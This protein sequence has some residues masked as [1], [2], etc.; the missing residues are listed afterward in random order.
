M[1]NEG[2]VKIKDKMNLYEKYW[3]TMANKMLN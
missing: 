1:V 3:I 2:F